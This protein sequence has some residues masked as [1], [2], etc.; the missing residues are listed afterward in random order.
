MISLLRLAVYGSLLTL[1]APLPPVEQ[2]AQG[3]PFI[4]GPIARLILAAS[5]VNEEQAPAEST[6]CGQD[7]RTHGTNSEYDHLD[8]E[9]SLWLSRPSNAAD[10]PEELFEPRHGT[11]LS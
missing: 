4:A 10:A 11:I 5:G 2:E 6:V 7:R 1:E 9:G 3:D 8:V